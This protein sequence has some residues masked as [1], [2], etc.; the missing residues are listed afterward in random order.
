MRGE[1]LEDPQTI[2]LVY[3]NRIDEL[4]VRNAQWM[5]GLKIRTPGTPPAEALAEAARRY[6]LAAIRLTPRT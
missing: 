3:A 6:P 1:L 5:I 4:G 2:A